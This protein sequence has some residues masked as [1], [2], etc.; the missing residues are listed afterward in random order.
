M[1]VVREKSLKFIGVSIMG[2]K[3]VK[4]SRQELLNVVWDFV[5]LDSEY[6]CQDYTVSTNLGRENISELG[7]TSVRSVV[8]RENDEVTIKMTF[9]KKP[10]V[11]QQVSALDCE[12]KSEGSSPSLG[13]K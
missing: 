10:M 7:T 6:T 9:K 3:Q 5:K 2:V 13:T 12:S 1:K 4:S 11:A 8:N